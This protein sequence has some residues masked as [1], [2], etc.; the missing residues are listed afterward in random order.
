MIRLVA[1]G[2]FIKD[3]LEIINEKESMSSKEV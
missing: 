3:G 1:E 2:V